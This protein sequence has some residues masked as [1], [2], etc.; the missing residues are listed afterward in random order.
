M[1][2]I[3]QKFNRV[4]VIA[5]A[6]VDSSRR[7]KYLC[8]CDCGNTLTLLGTTLRKGGGQGCEHCIKAANATKHGANAGGKRDRLYNIW[9]AMKDRCNN[10]NNTKYQ[11]YGGRGIIVCKEW[12]DNYEPFRD[13]ALTHGYE[14]TLTIDRRNNNGN[15]TP[16][17]CWWATRSDQM[18]N[19]RSC[20]YITIADVT[21]S[22]TKWCRH[23]GISVHSVRQ[24]IDK[25]HM[26][27]AVAIL[28]TAEYDRKK[29]EKLESL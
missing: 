25:G 16:D 7:K 28:Y 17:N 21:M 24:R 10:P 2:M 22:L 15:Y 14:D 5:E 27:P 20:R 9:L 4:T 8:Q 13:W 11:H 18:N 29:R 23:Y 6:G 3:G 1:Q 12:Q 26:D 19:S